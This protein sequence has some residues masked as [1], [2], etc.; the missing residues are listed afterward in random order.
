MK[1]E[2][3]KSLFVKTLLLTLVW[4]IWSSRS[5]PIGLRIVDGDESDPPQSDEGTTITSPHIE[6]HVY[7]LF[8]ETINHSREYQNKGAW[9][10]HC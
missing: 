4:S 7:H 5:R 3:S 1:G 8:L 9:P 6:S 2:S 10:T